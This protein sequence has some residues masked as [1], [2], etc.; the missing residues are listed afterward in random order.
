MNPLAVNVI[1]MFEGFSP[2]V[3]NCEGGYKTIGYGHCL[4]GGQEFPKP[5]TKEQGERLLL[6]DMARTEHALRKW[7]TVPLSTERE[8]AL[9]SFTFNVGSAALQRSTLRLKVN[10][11]EHEDV[12]RELMKWVFAGG[13]KCRGLQR[14]RFIEGQLYMH[15]MCE[16]N[17][18]S[19]L[20]R[21][22]WV[23]CFT[24]SFGV[25]DAKTNYGA[26]T[27]QDLHYLEH[28]KKQLEHAENMPGGL[29]EVRRLKRQIDTVERGTH[30]RTPDMQAFEER[31][32]RN[33][34]AI[35]EV[36]PKA[37]P[38]PDSVMLTDT[39][40]GRELDLFHEKTI[41][42]GEDYG[43]P[44]TLVQERIQKQR[45]QTHQIFTPLKIPGAGGL[46]NPREMEKQ[47]A[48]QT[49][50]LHGRPY[51][52]PTAQHPPQRVLAKTVP[53]TS[54]QNTQRLY[55]EPP[56]EEMGQ[57]IARP[58]DVPMVVGT[59]PTLQA[60]RQALP[61]TRPLYG[62]PPGYA[63]P[64]AQTMRAVVPPKYAPTPKPRV[65]WHGDRNEA[66]YL[67]ERLKSKLAQLAHARRQLQ[68]C[69]GS[70]ADAWSS[71]IYELETEKRSLLRMLKSLGVRPSFTKV[72]LN[73]DPEFDT[74]QSEEYMLKRQLEKT[75]HQE[76]RLRRQ[77]RFSKDP[78]VVTQA[79]EHLGRLERNRKL[80][81]ASLKGLKKNKE[82][83]DRTAVVERPMIYRF[84]AEE[85]PKD[86]EAEAEAQEEVQDEVKAP[87]S[88]TPQ[89]QERQAAPAVPHQRPPYGSAEPLHHRRLP[90]KVPIPVMPPA[91]TTTPIM[92]PDSYEDDDDEHNPGSFWQ[93]GLPPRDQY[94][95]QPEV[96]Q[97]VNVDEA[98]VLSSTWGEE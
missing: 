2:V 85:A 96:P 39:A 63:R 34:E 3:Y 83:V 4:E 43:V 40:A 41:T 16:G 20:K 62:T 30:I 18:E 54:P 27:R 98:R 80:L 78:E 52:R 58:R 86:T 65:A 92:E 6:K 88:E 11:Q 29:E 21:T 84:K 45:P 10:R 53:M 49:Q 47:P 68:G 90:A 79:G 95:P 12:P 61:V 51:Q 23:F 1:K 25:A 75:E 94:H 89:V 17:M 24:L 8:A 5:L 93:S 38:A 35:Q 97:R 14:R 91:K 67:E 19:F 15:R 50:T 60:P 76:K 36:K 22:L 81:E 9:L 48:I 69:G 87:E 26:R 56:T 74:V 82:G 66:A 57:P 72:S 64:Q 42:V 73:E 28:L 7:I 33:Q 13:K 31:Q 70:E 77:L 55:G 46:P 71:R 59:K 37:P 32:L 44:R